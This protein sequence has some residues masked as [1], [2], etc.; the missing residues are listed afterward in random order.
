MRCAALAASRLTPPVS[1]RKRS[2]WPPTSTV[3]KTWL[4]KSPMGS[5]AYVPPARNETSEKTCPGTSNASGGGAASIVIV[6]ISVTRSKRGSPLPLAI[7]CGSRSPPTSRRSS[8]RRTDGWPS[9][10]CTSRVSRC[11]AAS[12]HSSS[13]CPPCGTQRSTSKARPSASRRPWDSIMAGW[14]CGNHQPRALIHASVAAVRRPASA[15][16]TTTSPLGP[17]C[18]PWMPS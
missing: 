4:L 18:Q 10:S 13:H 5:R 9:C 12:N 16:C 15:S 14:R 2:A 7:R 3:T 6:V 1:S 17:R 11:V 8:K